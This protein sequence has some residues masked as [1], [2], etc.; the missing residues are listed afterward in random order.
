MCSYHGRQ[1][2]IV[3]V[4]PVKVKSEDVFSIPSSK[5]PLR[6]FLTAN[7]ISELISTL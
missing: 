6:D 2:Y 5:Q 3:R 7:S 4:Y 1:D